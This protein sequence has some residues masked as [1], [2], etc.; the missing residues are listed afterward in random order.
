MRSHLPIHRRRPDRG[1]DVSLLRGVP[2]FRHADPRLLAQLAAHTDRLRLP[3][4]RTL[5]RAGET[6]RALIAI[7]AGEATVASRDGR[8]SVLRP[9]DEIGARE[10]LRNQRHTATVV[11]T[12][13]I[14]VVV[15]NGPAVRWAHREGAG[16]WSPPVGHTRPAPRPSG[17]ERR[18][19][20]AG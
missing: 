18:A 7:V 11:A 13:D 14:E 8:L 9:G 19:R 15:V 20:L 1:R 6:A 4:G 3:P 12:G 16:R 5:V 2:S 10:L 17:L